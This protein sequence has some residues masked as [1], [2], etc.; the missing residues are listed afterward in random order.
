M[1]RRDRHGARVPSAPG[2]A[3]RRAETDRTRRGGPTGPPWAGAWG[4]SGPQ[5]WGHARRGRGR[6]G[7]HR[8]PVALVPLVV[9]AVTAVWTA[10]PWGGD[11]LVGDREPDVLAYG[12]LLV[13]AAVLLARRRSPTAAVV[14]TTAVAIV[15]PTLGYPTTGAFLLPMIVAFYGA[16]ARDVRRPAVVGGVVYLVSFVALGVV[17]GQV[18]PEAVLIVPVWVLGA[19][20]AGEGARNRR[21]FFAEARRRAREAERSRQEED[22]RRESDERVRIA[23][24]VHDVVS[25]SIAMINV[26]AG[27]AAHLLDDDPEQARTALVAIKEASRDALRDLRATLGVLRPVDDAAGDGRAPTPGLARLD[28]IAERLDGA[29]LAVDVTTTGIDG[30]L[31]AGVDL[32]AYR[33]V[34]E[35]VSNVLR[36]ANASVVRI[37]V[38]RR[39]DALHVEVADDGSGGP[40]SG[41]GTEEAA[42]DRGTRTIGRRPSSAPAHDV[43]TSDATGNGLRGMRERATALGGRVEAGPS[44]DGGWRVV[45]ELPVTGPVRDGRRDREQP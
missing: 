29:G 26:Q 14:G 19:L 36:H 16:M 35:A 20:V 13:A 30:P 37:D 38:T 5:P 25:H 9:A 4:A 34:Q 43:A 22:R 24:E 11:E 1:D 21:A 23:R 40:S 3:G 33:I 31:P 12:L 45:A 6:T 28:E 27:V 8:P 18:Q 39:G 42:T 7:A 44:P 41:R 17:P 15:Y 2:A 10:A 32:A